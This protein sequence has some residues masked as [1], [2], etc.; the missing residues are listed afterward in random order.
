MIF[1][2]RSP[3]QVVAPNT[4]SRALAAKLEKDLR[5]KVIVANAV[6]NPPRLLQAACGE[7]RSRFPIAVVLR[8]EAGPNSTSTSALNHCLTL[9]GADRTCSELKISPF[10]VLPPRMRASS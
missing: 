10:I 1:E 7:A 2:H 4:R 8:C 6:E 3:V 9:G 5:R